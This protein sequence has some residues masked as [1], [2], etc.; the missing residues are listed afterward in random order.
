MDLNNPVNQLGLN[1]HL[2]GPNFGR[3]PS[4]NKFKNIEIILNMFSDYNRIKQKSIPE[5]YLKK[6]PQNIWK[7]NHLFLNDL[8]VKEE[9]TR[10]I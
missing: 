7:L 5:K 9:I 8:C 4:C 10:K 2:D 6:N 1:I 3:Q